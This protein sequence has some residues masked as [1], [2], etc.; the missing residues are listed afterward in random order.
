MVRI[1]GRP[2]FSY[3][4]YDKIGRKDDSSSDKLETTSTLYPTIRT[5]SNPVQRASTVQFRG[6]FVV[7]TRSQ[8]ETGER[9]PINSEWKYEVTRQS[10]PWIII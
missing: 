1:I 3:F 10:V 6:S 2:F 7:V 8:L 5:A 4:L 9:Q